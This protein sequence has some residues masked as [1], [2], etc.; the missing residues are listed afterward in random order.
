ML[1]WLPPGYDDA[2]NASTTY[3]VLYMHD[4]QNLFSK[5]AT[6]PAEWQM[7]EVAGRLLKSQLVRPFIVVGIPHS[8]STR[9]RG[10]LCR[11]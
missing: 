9:P 1:V 10:V 4:G 11:R 3:P 7:D 8:G 6:A 2:A 5:P